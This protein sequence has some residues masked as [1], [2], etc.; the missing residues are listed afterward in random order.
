[1]LSQ[2]QQLVL[3]QQ[4]R[5]SMKLWLPLLQAPLQDLHKHLQTIAHDNPYIQIR[6][7]QGQGGTSDVIEKTAI[8]KESLYDRLYAQIGP[9]LFPTEKSINIAHL[10]IESIDDEGF[11]EGDCVLMAQEL[12]VSETEVERIRLRFAYLDPVGI[13]AKDIQESFLFQIEEFE[14]EEDLYQLI[15]SMIYEMDHIE[16][17]SHHPL[18][19]EARRVFLKLRNP[20]SGEKEEDGHFIP[21]ELFIRQEGGELVV[22]TNSQYYPDIKLAKAPGDQAKWKEAREMARLIELRVGTLQKI[23]TCLAQR[24]REFFMGGKLKPLRMQEVADAIEVNQSTVSRA[25]AHKFFE[26]DRGIFPFKTLFVTDRGNGVTPLEIRQLLADLIK[27]ENSEKPLS[28]QLLCQ[29]INRELGLSINRRSVVNYRK[30][31]GV[32]STRERKK[33]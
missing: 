6:S 5:L 30:T 11:F 23:G 7:R 4:P 24:Q 1:M 17:F 29:I 8:A 12:G 14:L 27:N 3:K 10:I 25:V 20:P 18:Y 31:L 22:A 9:P 19:D 33:P 28:D 13:G 2:K 32:G 15:K 16:R 21:P 26:C